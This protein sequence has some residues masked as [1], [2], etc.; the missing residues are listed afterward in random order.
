MINNP[1]PENQK[2]ASDL[3]DEAVEHWK[4]SQVVHQSP[5]WNGQPEARALAERIASDSPESEQRLFELLGHENQLVVAYALVTLQ[6]M[7]SA[8]L[9]EIPRNLLESRSRVTLIAGSFSTSTDLGSLARQI[10]KRSRAIL[11]HEHSH[12]AGADQPSGE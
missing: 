7:N 6:L 8:R 5:S 12:G 2:A 3:L 10:Q 1:K 4:H 9:V 11:A